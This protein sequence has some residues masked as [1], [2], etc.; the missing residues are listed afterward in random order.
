M[1]VTRGR[2]RR[3]RCSGV[4]FWLNLR[5]AEGQAAV[6][7]DAAHC[8]GS[9]IRA[10]SRQPREGPPPDCPRPGACPQ[11]PAHLPTM[12][13]SPRS[14]HAP[15]RSKPMASGQSRHWY[16]RPWMGYR[17]ARIAAQR[18]HGRWAP[19]TGTLATSAGTRSGGRG[20]AE[21]QRRDRRSAGRRPS[22]GCAGNASTHSIPQHST[23]APRLTHTPHRPAPHHI[24]RSRPRGV[25]RRR[26]S[27]AAGWLPAA[28]PAPDCARPQPGAA[29]ARWPAPGSAPAAAAGPQGPVSPPPPPAPPS[30]PAPAAAWLPAALPAAG[31][32]GVPAS[33][34]CPAA[35]SPRT[36]CDWLGGCTLPL[37][38]PPPSA[39]TRS[40]AACWHSASLRAD[41]SGKS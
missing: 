39:A 21:D 33:S 29:A 22:R 11:P 6:A 28:Q 12:S 17:P 35:A 31:A 10:L 25:C 27:A 37:P 23:D 8:A 18:R 36:C 41:S 26:P 20:W 16:R 1:A 32:R 40:C 38:P 34:P 14:M 7:V 5:A 30:S 4:C 19:P 9:L 13:D 3:M 24:R 15:H 2:T